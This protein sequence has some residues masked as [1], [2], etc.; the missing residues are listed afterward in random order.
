M[1]GKTYDAIVLGL[2]AMGS[3][4]LYHLA[5][6]GVRVCGIE[7]Y[8]VAHDRG[9]SH[10]VLRAIRKA[11]FEH[12]DYVPLLERAY[13]LWDALQNESGKNLFVRN[14]MVLSMSP[15]STTC[16]GL[17]QSYD[18]HKL[19][20][21]QL[22]ASEAQTRY[23]QFHFPEDHTVFYDPDA[24]FLFVER[25]IEE[26]IRLAQGYEADVRIHH[27]AVGWTEDGAEVVVK[28]DDEVIRGNHL[29]ITAGAWAGP[30]LAELGV[31]LQIRRKT[32][33]WYAF[34]DMSRIVP[35]RFPVF[36]FEMM[37]GMYYGFPA[38]DETGIKIANHA[39]GQPVA[40]PDALDRGLSVPDEAPFLQFLSKVFPNE[41][42]RRTHF[43][44]QIPMMTPV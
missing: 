41:C 20:H 13:T 42:P 22:D 38:V 43:S 26:H 17:R 14:G 35:E 1:A 9:S 10:G 19:P 23:P 32:Q 31:P 6:R 39:G 4:T 27:D 36:F 28:T 24:G 5:K 33:F 40:D 11:Y 3:A 34:D 2:G 44:V 16:D 18:L 29:V 21:E 30:L 25:C 8:G 15:E 12:P 7:R 37:G